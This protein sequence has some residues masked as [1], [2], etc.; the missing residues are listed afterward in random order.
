MNVDEIFA[1]V[2]EKSRPVRDGEVFCSPR[3]G[4]R[5]TWQSFKECYEHAERLQADLGSGW[6]INIWDNLGWHVDLV[7]AD[8]HLNRALRVSIKWPRKPHEPILYAASMEKQA[9]GAADYRTLPQGSVAEAIAALGGL[10][11]ESLEAE[12]GSFRVLASTYA[13]ATKTPEA[14]VIELPRLGEAA[15]EG[16]DR[17]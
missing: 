1:H 2:P 4:F 9:V 8:P 11:R 14:L 7:N 16:E 13:R 10:L 5:C 17:V 12:M 15:Q 3:C 6:S